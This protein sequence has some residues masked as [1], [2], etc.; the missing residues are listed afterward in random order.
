[1]SGLKILRGKK[2]KSGGKMM[3]N[4]LGK[5]RL[6]ELLYSYIYHRKGGDEQICV[7]SGLNKIGGFVYKKYG[8]VEL[9]ECEISYGRQRHKLE[10]YSHSVRT[11]KKQVTL[12]DLVFN[13]SEGCYEFFR[14]ANALYDKDF[15]PIRICGENLN[16]L[17]CVT[18][19]KKPFG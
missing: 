13:E 15:L 1:M 16:P 8:G 14:K 18:I 11:G 3:G 17:E 9:L 10:I 19:A 12:F 2:S 6:T 4:F 7:Y 5:K